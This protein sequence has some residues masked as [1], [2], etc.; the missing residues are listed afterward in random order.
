MAAQKQEV[1]LL[2]KA[3]T[4]GL[5]SIGQLVKELEALGQD[6]GEASEK[7]EGLADSLKGLRD[8]QKLVKQFADLKGQTKELAAAQ[9]DAKTRATELG[10]ALA[11]TE[12]PSK[13]QRTE[14]EKARQAA[15]A[16]GQA[17][18]NN[19]VQLNGLRTSLSDAG[20]ST[21]NLSDEQLRIKREI[22][23][24]DEEIS[25]VT[26]ELTEMRDST[27]AA[28]DGSRQLGDDVAESG[29]RVS[30][31]RERLQELSPTLGK[32]GAGLKVA[33][34]AVAGFLA[35]VGA[36]AATL[37]IFSRSQAAVA[38]ELTNTGNALDANREQLQLWRIAGDR[39]GLS[40]EKVSDILKRMTERL[41]EFSATGSGEAGNVLKRLNLDIRDLVNL[42]PDEQ[43]LAIANA[44]GEIGSKSEQ[45]ALLEKLAS[46]SSQLQPLLENNAAGLK[47]IFEE[48]QKGGAIYT[49]AELDKLNKA[50]D[51]Y[52]RIDLK[53]QGLT[54]RIGAELA[55]VV[56]EATDKL[57]DLFDQSEAG[58]KLVSLFKR[59][60]ERA[61]E[62][63]TE[64]SKDTG[65]VAGQFDRILS[66]LSIVGSTLKGVFSFA[67]TAI[68]AFGTLVAGQFAII[69][70]GAEK[71]AGALE[72]VGAITEE[73]YK[74]VADLAA[75]ARKETSDLADSTLKWGGNTLSA[76]KDIVGVF[77]DV[78]EAAKSTAATLAEVGETAEQSTKELLAASEAQIAALSKQLGELESQ[79]ETAVSRTSQAWADYYAV[80]GEAQAQALKELNDAITA[81]NAL[82]T[83]SGELAQKISKEQAESERLVKDLIED[84]LAAQN[85]AVEASR[86][87][88]ANLGVDVN[89]VMK[90]ISK[91]AQEA[92]DGI[93]TLADEI[94]KAGLKGKQAAQAFEDG[95]TQALES[96]SNKKEFDALKAKIESLGESGELGAQGVKDALEEISKKAKETAEQLEADL[97]SAIGSAK[98]KE[99]LDELKERIE[100]LKE[101][102]EVGAEGAN[103]AL[104][105]IR[106]KMAELQGMDLNIGLDDVP[107]QAD[108]ATEGLDKVKGKVKQ[109]AEEAEKLRDGF[110]EALGNAFGAA[111][112][113]ARVSVTELSAAT[114]NL[115][116][117]KMG[118]DAF[119]EDS[120]NL[121]A[122]LEKTRETVYRFSTQI[123]KAREQ[124]N[125]LGIWFTEVGL[126]AAEARQE[127]YYQAIAAEELTE[128]V[129]AG[130]YS[131][132]EL[133]RLSDSAANK[134]SLLNE[135]R[136]SGLQSAIDA[137]R[138]KI[139]SLNSSAESTL[140]SLAQRLADIQGNTEEAQR[141]QYEA[142]KKRLVEMQRQAQQEGADNAA[143]DY[144]KALDQLKQI[145]S[146]EQKNRTDAEN[147]REKEAA[148]RAAQQEQAERER[149]S[150]ERQRNTTTNNQ[151]SQSRSRQ[152]IVL[153]SPGGG[154]T[155]IQTEDPQ[156]LLQ[157]LEQAGL[158]SAR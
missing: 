55:P 41:G 24:V 34:V 122:S 4:E 98:T 12:N 47:A 49:D 38:D 149:Q 156:G 100:S 15:K 105:T 97:S 56:G 129:Q 7:L 73:S 134:F 125:G 76:G 144:G 103:A 99:E 69:L 138:S 150:S 155:E 119:V 135:Q 70:T 137:A 58:E 94:E 60:T 141:L 112:T 44:I 151:Q 54:K 6:T 143:A 19:Q 13:A 114:R 51:V 79:V 43:M 127:F 48:A 59:L 2:I 146:I 158:R 128:K 75:R 74:K 116:E 45:V 52:N 157:I 72:S 152:T 89:K 82:R 109:T 124:I 126:A 120:E 110:R 23:G 83:E 27:R 77:F 35:T 86:E 31:F 14:F 106:Q 130:A 139:E 132:E 11:E 131:M 142:E 140:N 123:A 26:A 22:S 1:E 65:N 33:G 29:D 111:L 66:I 25:G 136:L 5:K 113:K 133:A 95:F 39:V 40:G 21:S 20:V 147:A 104:E 28:A 121:D 64:L 102:G 91:D 145:N 107:D 84:R 80:S 57:I 32:I 67:R 118:M 17:W 9:D 61:A 92:I 42:K 53:L 101:S 148:D 37:S 85:V 3:G 46:D 8:Q 30:G 153:Q 96:T 154:Q 62:F 87:A 10:K 71:L 88:L 63:I 36:S 90:G 68:S 115:F 81:E 16:A 50:N 117:K 18:Q 93:D 78:E 108:D